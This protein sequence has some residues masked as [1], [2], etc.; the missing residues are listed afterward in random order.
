MPLISNSTYKAP[1]FL[2]NAHSN[3]VYAALVRKVLGVNYERQRIDTPDDDFLDLDWSCCGNQRLV[4]ALHGL[5]GNADRPYMR[6]MIKHFN[7]NGWDGLGFNFRGCSGELNNHAFSYHMGWT[8]DL[9]YIIEQIQESDKYKEIALVGFSMGGNVILNYLGRQGEAVPTIVKKA[10]TFSVPCHIESA[11]VEIHKFR[12]AL[13]LRRFM[14]SLEEKVKAK[15]V[16]FPNEITYDKKNFPS[17]FYEFDDLYT[18]PLNGFKDNE[19]YWRSTSSTPY[20]QN[21]AIPTI[22]I[23]AKDDTF[24]SQKCFPEEVAQ[25]HPYFH[26]ETTK[27]GGHVGFV[28]FNKD[29]SYWSERRALAFISR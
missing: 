17:D 24:L 19:D 18:A 26:L 28:S 10:V 8:T 6:G 29:G 25:N 16:D 4:I 23:N 9:A 7:S 14:K 20:L 27:H 22:L 2:R 11:N 12:N 5:E 21:I 15:A 13:Y 3:T 1:L